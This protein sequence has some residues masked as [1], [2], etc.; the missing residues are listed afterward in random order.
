MGRVEQKGWLVRWGDVVD[1]Y[2]RAQALEEG[3]L[4]D[5]SRMAKEAG[6]RFPVALTYR[7]WIDAIAWDEAN[8]A[9]Q[10]EEGRLWDVLCLASLA[11]KRAGA[12]QSRVSFEVLRVPNTRR[13]LRPTPTELV[14]HIGPG[15]AGEP[16]MTIMKPGED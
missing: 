7:A 14:M 1:S 13:A 4:I 9:P 11:A 8:D 10:D 3:V 2:S 12:G 6:F 16:V 15:D 5:V